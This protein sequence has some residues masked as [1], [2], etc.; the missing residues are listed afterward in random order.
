[1]E[2]IEVGNAAFVQMMWF[3]SA[4]DEQIGAERETGARHIMDQVTRAHVRVARD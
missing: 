2:W 1:M 3:E 4:L